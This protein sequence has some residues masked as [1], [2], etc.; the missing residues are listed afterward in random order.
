MIDQNKDWGRRKIL[1]IDCEGPEWDVF[2]AM[3][4]KILLEFEQIVGEWHL[5]IKDYLGVIDSEKIALQTRVMNKLNKIFYIF[6]VQPNNFSKI[7]DYDGWVWPR[8]IGLGMV[9]KDLVKNQVVQISLC[10]LPIDLPNRSKKH[11]YVLNFFPFYSF[12]HDRYR[13]N[14]YIKNNC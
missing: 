12:S 14:E 8:P 9:R 4:V 1:K 3:D 11:D 5:L 13:S 10:N 6:E 7:L 2:D